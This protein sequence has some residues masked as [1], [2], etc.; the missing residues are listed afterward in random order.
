MPAFISKVH[1]T[2]V[3]GIFRNNPAYSG[4]FGIFKRQFLTDINL[5]NYPEFIE[6]NC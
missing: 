6:I 2:G 5:V 4:I 1:A 3:Y